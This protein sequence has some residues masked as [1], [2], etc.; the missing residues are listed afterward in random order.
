MGKARKERE[1]EREIEI[2]RER[3]SESAREKERERVFCSFR[4]RTRREYL[5]ILIKIV[6]MILWN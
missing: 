3:E 2:E 1:T 4:Q 5:K 6:S